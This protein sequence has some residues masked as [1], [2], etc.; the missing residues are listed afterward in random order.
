M[1]FIAAKRN[2][3]LAIDPEHFHRGQL[4]AVELQELC[5]W[6]IKTNRPRKAEFQRQPS[7]ASRS[8]NKNL[9]RTRICQYSSVCH[10]NACASKRCST[11]RSA[12]E[13]HFGSLLDFHGNLSSKITV[14]RTRGPNGR[15]QFKLA[16]K[17]G[18][19]RSLAKAVYPSSTDDLRYRSSSCKEINSF[20]KSLLSMMNEANLIIDSVS[21]SLL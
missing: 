3:R 6:P 13:H 12:E 7:H 21:M 20:P 19:T 16:G 5:N 14:M 17:C 10:A 18:R 4:P 8:L 9:N 1:N 15:L 11:L 2:P